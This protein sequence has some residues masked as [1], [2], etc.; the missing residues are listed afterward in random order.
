MENFHARENY[1]NTLGHNGKGSDY[2]RAQ[3]SPHLSSEN[4]KSIVNAIA[5]LSVQ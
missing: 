1:G 3:E 2:P 5:S 4:L